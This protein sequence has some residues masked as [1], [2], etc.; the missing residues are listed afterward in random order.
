MNE[1]RDFELSLAN[2]ASKMNMSLK[3]ILL[4]AKTCK[5]EDCFV[6]PNEEFEQLLEKFIEENNV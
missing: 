6:S 3:D 5:E 4:F 2:L 1:N